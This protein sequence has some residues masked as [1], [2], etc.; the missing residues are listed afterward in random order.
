MARLGGQRG[1]AGQARRYLRDLEKLFAEHGY[2]AALYGHFGDGVTHCRVNFDFHSE[3]G[4]ESYR[5]FMREAAELVHSYGGSLSGEHGDGQSRARASRHHVR[6]RARAMFPRVQG[7]LGPLNRL[8][9]GKAIEPFPIDSNLRL[10]LTYEPKQLDTCF[11]F[12]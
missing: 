11:R 2:T 3:P 9:P 8:N 12:P 1:A 7:D 5:Q 6:R 4:L 10:G